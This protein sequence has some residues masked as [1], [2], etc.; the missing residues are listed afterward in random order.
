MTPTDTG[1]LVAVRRREKRSKLLVGTE[2]AS[3]CMTG[4][5]GVLMV[6]A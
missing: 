6:K 4:G 2:E 1:E 5:V 3:T